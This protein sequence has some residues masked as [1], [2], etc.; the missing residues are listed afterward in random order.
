MDAAPS[1][2]MMNDGEQSATDPEN[3]CF[4]TMLTLG[5]DTSAATIASDCRDAALQFINESKRWTKLE[6]EM[7]LTARYAPVTRYATKENTP[8]TWPVPLLRDIDARLVERIMKSART[9]IMETLAAIAKDGSASFVLRAL[10]AGTVVRCEDAL[11]KPAWAPTGETAR[12]ADRVLSFF[13]VDYLA[14]PGDYETKLFVCP[15]CQSVTF[16]ENVRLRGACDQHGGAYSIT[17]PRRH[18]TL[19]YP[20]LGA[21]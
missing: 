10:I 5:P 2:S 8:A 4:D 13:A 7:W 9:E 1:E 19:P 6:L 11:G 15:A 12:L 18:S 3:T 21:G 20:P 14:Q 16:D 17:A